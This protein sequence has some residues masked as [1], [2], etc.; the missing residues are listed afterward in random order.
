MVLRPFLRAL[1]HLGLG[2]YYQLRKKPRAAARFLEQAA[3]GQAQWVHPA[4]LLNLSSVHL[5]LKEPGKALS[6]L[7]QVVLALK[8][9]IGPLCP[10]SDQ[11]E[12][13]LEAAQTAVTQVLGPIK[14]HCASALVEVDPFGHG[15]DLG[16]EKGRSLRVVPGHL[17]DTPEVSKSTVV[18]E[19]K[20]PST[21][22]RGLGAGF[23][24][25]GLGRR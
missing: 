18:Q 22:R 7:C 10:N 13:A 8:N 9:S 14:D 16:E 19:A 20:V 15:I 4:I 3:N 6:C 25:R 23:G 11:V 1:S 24:V 5:L 12:G 2:Q 17:L 21:P